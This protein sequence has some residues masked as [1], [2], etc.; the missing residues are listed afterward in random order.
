MLAIYSLIHFL[1][2]IITYPFFTSPAFKVKSPLSC[3]NKSP[4]TFLVKISALMSLVLTIF[5]WNDPQLMLS[6]NARKYPH[7]LS[8]AGTNVLLPWKY[9]WHFSIQIGKLKFNPNREQHLDNELDLLSSF[10]KG[11]KLC[12]TWGQGN[13]W[14][15]PLERHKIQS[16]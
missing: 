16:H 6:Q 15:L 1:F 12:F 4:T 3:Q 8:G 13:W 7:A 9:H 14:R 10:W 2:S 11:Y 5:W